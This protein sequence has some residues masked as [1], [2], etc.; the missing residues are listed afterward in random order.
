M[1]RSPNV[2]PCDWKTLPRQLLSLSPSPLDFSVFACKAR[3]LSRI[4]SPVSFLSRISSPISFTLSNLV[5]NLV[6]LESRLGPRLDLLIV[7]CEEN[8]WKEVG[9]LQWTSL[10]L[11]RLRS[12]RT[13][14]YVFSD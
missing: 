14:F 8:L 12:C 2:A 7:G 4:S 11:C 1:V 3:F 5:S 13:E 6:S 10:Y 9:F